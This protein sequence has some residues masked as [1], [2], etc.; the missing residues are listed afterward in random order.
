M[1]QHHSGVNSMFTVI[2][3]QYW[4]P[5]G[6]QCIQS[7][8]RKC[9]V[10]KKTAGR[11]YTIPEP[12]PL[13]KCCVNNAQPFKVTGVNFT[14]VL[15]VHSCKGE[16]KVFVCLFTCAVSRVIHLEIVIDFTVECYLAHLLFWHFHHFTI[17]TKIDVVWQCFHIFS[18]SWGA[19]EVVFICK[20]S[21]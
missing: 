18:Y 21:L 8:L 11:S 17:H 16:Q 14:E 19:A 3:K 13:E 5:L 9:V 2:R 4:I 7:L 1:E 10:C 15:Y 12:P 20:E 6:R